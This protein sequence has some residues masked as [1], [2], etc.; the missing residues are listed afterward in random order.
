MI[1]FPDGSEKEG[2]FDNNVFIGK[3]KEDDGNYATLD[4]VKIYPKTYN[5]IDKTKSVKKL[6]YEKLQPNVREKI[7]SFIVNRNRPKPLIKS[8]YMKSGGQANKLPTLRS[9]LPKLKSPLTTSKNAKTL[10]KSSRKW[11][12]NRSGSKNRTIIR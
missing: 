4:A 7:D 3:M 9:S 10:Y 11:H 6:K 5:K 12:T 8:K 2:Y 1:T